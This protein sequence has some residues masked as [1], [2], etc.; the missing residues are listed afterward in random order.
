M[1]ILLSSDVTIRGG[2]DGYVFDVAGALLQAGHEPVLAIEETTTSALREASQILPDVPLYR[3]AL[4]RRRHHRDRLR[5]AAE[6]LIEEVAP[7]GLHIVCGSPFSCLVLRE[8]A[9]QR[10]LPSVITEQQIRCDLTLA[11]DDAARILATYRAAKN[12]IFVSEGNRATMSEL[13][14]LRDVAH[15][16]IP[17]GVDV[18]T[19]A[20]RARPRVNIGDR[21][22]LLMTAARFSPEKRLDVLVRA[23][24][25]LPES[26]VGA[27]DLYGEGTE[28][29]VLHQLIIDLGVEH[30]VN[31]HPWVPN[32][33]EQMAKH[34]LFILPSDAEGMPYAL[35][36]AMAAGI[37]I[38]ASDVP[39]NVEALGGGAAGTLVPQGDVNALVT[40]LRTRIQDP[41]GTALMAR[42]ARD[43]VQTLYDVSVQMQRTVSLWP[44]V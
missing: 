41:G 44:S 42:R 23:A 6:T 20:A 37:P 27:V 13:V 32:I 14:D 1:R 8:I 19:I 39:G 22:V 15:T 10:E 5:E 34:D 24:A 43:R 11:P 30:R 26:L 18:R 17:N 33:P 2:V 21:P 12:V 31:L 4:Y 3:V 29:H 16:V 7:D 36:E 38:V 9:V 40:S 35:L 25:K 28:R